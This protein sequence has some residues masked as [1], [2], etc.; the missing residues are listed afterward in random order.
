MKDKK[1]TQ[2][3]PKEQVHSEF[4]TSA[5]NNFNVVREETPK[6]KKKDTDRAEPL[7]E[8]PEDEDSVKNENS[9]GEEAPKMNAEED[10]K[11]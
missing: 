9:G 1:H 2:D 5:G 10:E 8:L 6:K 4:E 11:S 3:K 7:N